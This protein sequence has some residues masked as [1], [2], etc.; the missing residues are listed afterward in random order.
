MI[1]QSHKE[2]KKKANHNPMCFTATTLS[3]SSYVRLLST[4]EKPW[5]LQHF[6][7]SSQFRGGEGGLEYKLLLH[8]CFSTFPEELKSLSSHLTLHYD[9]PSM[10]ISRSVCENQSLKTVLCDL[11]GSVRGKYVHESVRGSYGSR[12]W[13]ILCIPTG[14]GHEKRSTY[15]SPNKFQ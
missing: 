3:H 12:Q 5:L 10:W 7:I 15:K 9:M 13:Q 11:S 14:E 8:S 1:I 2:K 6:L 4:Q